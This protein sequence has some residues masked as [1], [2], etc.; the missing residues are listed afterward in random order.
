MRPTMVYLMLLLGISGIFAV[1]DSNRFG[2]AGG[3]A[4]N[5]ICASDPTDHCMRAPKPALNESTPD[6]QTA[7][8]SLRPSTSLRIH[9]SQGSTRRLGHAFLGFNISQTTTV[10]M[11]K[12]SF[13]TALNSIEPETLRGILGGTP[14]NPKTS[15]PGG[16]GPSQGPHGR[17]AVWWDLDVHPDL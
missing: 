2:S 10:A 15:D 1:R 12:S 9:A 16:G 17:E 8:A 13:S 7:S 11:S 5:N 14:S 4:P 3:S 6:L